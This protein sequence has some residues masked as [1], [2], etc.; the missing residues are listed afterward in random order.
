MAVLFPENMLNL[1]VIDLRNAAASFL[2][3][4]PKF[5]AVYAILTLHLF[6]HE[7][8]VGDDPQAPVPVSDGEFQGSEK[9]G[10]LSKI[11]GPGAQ[12]FAQFGKYPSGRILDVNAEAGRARI[13]ARSSVAVSDNS[14]GDRGTKAAI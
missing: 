3:K 10:I 9:R 7:F 11:V 5:R 6:D 12:V 13:A 8:R 2:V 14:V 4:G 1:K